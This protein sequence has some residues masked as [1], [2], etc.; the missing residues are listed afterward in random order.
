[1]A[2]LHEM[3]LFQLL[4]ADVDDDFR[5]LLPDDDGLVAHAAREEE[6]FHRLLA[7]REPRRVFTDA[8]L[9]LRFHR[10]R[11]LEVAIRGRRAADSLV[12]A[13]KVV[14]AL[15]PEL[16]TVAQVVD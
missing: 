4:F 2:F 10:V 8:F 13:L 5:A 6:G 15:D 7:E 11:D 16:E 12:R 1:M 14:V 3:E 9:D